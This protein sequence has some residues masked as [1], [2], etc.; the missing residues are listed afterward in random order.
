MFHNASQIIPR[1]YFV[2]YC[3]LISLKWQQRKNLALLQLCS[4]SGFPLLDS[5]CC[6]SES[7][8][9][10]SLLIASVFESI[11]L[12]SS[13]TIAMHGITKRDRRSF[14]IRGSSEFSR[15]SH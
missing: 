5:H 1:K 8:L 4:L 15:C 9:T 6:Q 13:Y 2:K 12:I 14:S 7:I 11:Y 10:D 3:P